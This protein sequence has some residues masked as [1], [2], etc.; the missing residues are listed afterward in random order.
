M[1]KDLRRRIVQSSKHFNIDSYIKQLYVNI[2]TA[3]ENLAFTFEG[4]PLAHSTI[5]VS[6]SGRSGTTWVGDVITNAIP[7]VQQIFEPL[8]PTFSQTVRVLTGY[9]SQDPYLRSYFL[10]SSSFDSQ[11]YEYWQNILTGKERSYWTDVERNTFFPKRYLIKEIR[12]N[13]MLGFIAKQFNPTII[14]IIR[15]PC[16]VIHSRLFKVKKKWHATTKDILNQPN[17]ISTYLEPWIDEIAAEQDPMGCHAIWWAIEN[18]VAL[19][20]LKHYSS[21]FTFYEY[22]LT[23]PQ[24]YYT[25]LFEQINIPFVDLNMRKINLPTR[26]AVDQRLSLQKESTLTEWKNDLTTDQIDRILQWAHRLGVTF[27]DSNCMPR[28]QHLI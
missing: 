3:S 20:E 16:A 15:H 23:D 26:M 5:F 14:L 7:R 27:Y 13:L 24:K 1:N 22:L 25:L 19:K 28:Y 12:A 10:S 11:W 8:H 2:G 4:R 18:M 21:C 9:N 6:G 17:L